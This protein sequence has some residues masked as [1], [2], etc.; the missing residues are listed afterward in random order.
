[1]D[2]FCD[3]MR[4]KLPNELTLHNYAFVNDN[5]CD[6][7]E[8]IGKCKDIYLDELE[9]GLE[10]IIKWRNCDEILQLKE[11]VDDIC[12]RKESLATYEDIADIKSEIKSKAYSINKNIQKLFPKVRRWTNLSTIVTVPVALCTLA[13]GN[14][15]MS[16]ISSGIAGVSKVVDEYMKYYTSK[17]SWVGFIN[18]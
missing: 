4:V 14:L 17:H 13:T 9:D 10:K 3:I 1:M 7:C 12:K 15:E 18:R 16:L 2:A 8:N 5:M 6:T 11:V